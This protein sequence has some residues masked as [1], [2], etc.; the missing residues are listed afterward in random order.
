MLEERAERLDWPK[1]I[2]KKTRIKTG[3][4]LSGGARALVTAEDKELS[5]SELSDLIEV[6]NQRLNVY[7]LKD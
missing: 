7:G 5:A 1:G 6:T 2:I 4:D 3:L